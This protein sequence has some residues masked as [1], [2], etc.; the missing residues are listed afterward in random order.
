MTPLPDIETL[1]P[2]RAP[3]RLIDCVIEIADGAVAT[4]ASVPAGGPFVTPDTDP[5]GYMVIEMMAQTVAAWN[6]W[7]RLQQEH[8]P[9]IG[10]LLGTRR[11]RCDR[12]TL[13]PGTTVRI[14]A[15]LVFSDGEMACFA[16]TVREADA[17][18]F[19]E[20]TLNVFCPAT[21][22]KTPP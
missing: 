19:A 11:F 10:Y 20:A 8:E 5:P 22:S 2:H 3:M 12:A 1:I 9:R 4:Q 17:P 13:A 16:C 18:P 6:G 14:A 7:Q 15:R 21:P